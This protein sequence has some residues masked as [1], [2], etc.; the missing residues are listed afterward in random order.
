MP[1]AV[2]V[3]VEA[4]VVVVE[5]PLSPPFP[6]LLPPFPPLL[7]PLDPLD[8]V[9]DVE[10]DEAAVVVAAAALFALETEIAAPPPLLFDEPVFLELSAVVVRYLVT[11]TV[12]VWTTVLTASVTVLQKV[13]VSKV[14]FALGRALTEN[15]E[16][17]R[18]K[19][20]RQVDFENIVVDLVRKEGIRKKKGML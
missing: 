20:A 10:P 17:A 7:P 3:D 16:N 18:V 1:V 9:D 14:P 15:V 12:L 5:E 11:S 2:V 19:R 4:A 6:P 13:S 8:P